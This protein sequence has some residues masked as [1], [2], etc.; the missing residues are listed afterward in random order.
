MQVDYLSGVS[1][2]FNDDVLNKVGFLSESYFMYYEDVDW[3]IRA[4]KKGIRLMINLDTK[5]FHNSKKYINFKLKSRSIFNRIIL[6]IKFYKF[7]IFLVLLYSMVSFLFNLI[8]YTF[9][10]KNVK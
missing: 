2:F 4:L 9:I 5:V 8:K 1:L 10:I 3:S 7:N 6:S